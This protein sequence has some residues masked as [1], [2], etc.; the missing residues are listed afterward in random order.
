MDIKKFSVSD[1][2]DSIE[3]KHE[4]VVVP[5]LLY[6]A[7]SVLAHTVHNFLHLQEKSM[8]ASEVHGHS[9]RYMSIPNEC[10]QVDFGSGQ[11]I[12]NV[13]SACVDVQLSVQGIET[14]Y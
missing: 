3:A 12:P 7:K 11:V 6:S 8:D 1:E 10:V 14:R 5:S 4:S 9:V 2:A 13:S